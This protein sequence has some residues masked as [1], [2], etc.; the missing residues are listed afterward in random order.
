MQGA[1]TLGRDAALVQRW[2]AALKLVP[3]YPLTPSTKPPVVADVRGGEP[4][5]FNVAVPVLPV[6]P[7]GEVNWFSPVEEK[8]LFARTVE[9]IS[10]TGYNST[11][12]LAGTRAR[13][14]LPGTHE[15]ITKTFQ[16]RQMPSGCLQL[17]G[18]TRG[19][20]TE[21]FAACGIVSEML[22]QSVGGIIRLFPA[23]PKQTDARFDRLRAEGG[24]VVS[25][26]QH[27]GQVKSVAVLSTAGGKLRW[28]NP[29]GTAPQAR[30]NGAV[31]PVTVDGA[32]IC[33][34]D[35]AT[36]DMIHLTPQP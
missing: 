24:F 20:Y 4:I 11:M 5:E 33:S 23:W 16:E 36:G 30:K 32:G 35:T 13:L 19:N 26:T 34:L 6:F 9:T 12:I 21:Q 28:V 10:W 15:W 17:A 1:R 2:E 22:L 14:S 27:S 31:V 25:A 3:D 8:A 18:D 29:L 7:V